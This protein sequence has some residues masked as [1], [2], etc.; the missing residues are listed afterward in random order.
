MKKEFGLAILFVFTMIFI[1][2]GNEKKDV[3]QESGK[4]EKVNIGG[5][6][7]IAVADVDLAAGE[8]I[9][10]KYCHIC[11][12]DGIAGAPKLG[13]KELWGPRAEKG[14]TTLIKHVTEGYTGDSGVM[15]MKG[16]CM[17]CTEEEFRNAISFLLSKAE[18]TAK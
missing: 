2:C 5:V 14:M 16:T 8:V 3:K 7:A 1:S 12:K 17:N 4:T 6:N 10:N 9:Y 15:P 11:H 13:N 18:L